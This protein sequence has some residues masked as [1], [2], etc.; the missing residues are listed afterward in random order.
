MSWLNYSLTSST[1]SNNPNFTAEA[2]E[3]RRKELEAKRLEAAKKREARKAILAAGV[4]VPPSPSISNPPSPVREHLQSLNLPINT[5]PE[6]DDDLLSLPGDIPINNMAELFE[7]KSTED[8]KEAWKKSVTIK[9]DKHDVE[10][11]FTAVEAEMKS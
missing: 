7:S 3:T 9:F 10:Y 2:R 1:R 6:V 11:F 5:I 8:D 4:S